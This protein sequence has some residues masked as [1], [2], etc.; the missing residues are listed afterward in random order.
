MFDRKFKCKECGET[1]FK[2]PIKRHT[3]DTRCKRKPWKS[4]CSQCGRR[5]VDGEW[6]T[7][8]EIKHQEF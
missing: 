2:Q 4:S 5:L 6:L 7:I 8:D 3:R 1:K